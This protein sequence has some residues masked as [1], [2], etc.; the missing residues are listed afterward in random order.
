MG[1]LGILQKKIVCELAFVNKMEYYVYKNEAFLYITGDE[2]SSVPQPHKS[3]FFVVFCF[4]IVFVSIGSI[5][6]IRN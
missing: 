1:D 6:L 5:N 3:K 4:Y 2:G